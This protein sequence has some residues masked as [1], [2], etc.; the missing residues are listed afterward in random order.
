MSAADDIQEVDRLPGLPHPR[1][2][3]ALIGQSA[4][5][6]AFLD[7]YKSGRFPH[8]WILAGPE[9]VGKATFAYR[10]ARFVLSHPDFR[11]PQVQ[12]AR[13]LSVPADAPS[14]RRIVAQSH[15]SL[16]VLN[17]RW[18]PEKK[19]LPTEIPSDLVRK[20]VSFFGSTAGEGGWRVCIV[21]S[22]EDMNVTGMN[23]LLKVVEEPPDRSLFLIVSHLPGRL[24]PTIRSRCRIAPFRVL[25]PAEIAE[26][27]E[28][29]APGAFDPAT[30]RRAA[31]VADGS[32]RG[33]FK[34]LDEDTLAIVEHIRA[35]LERLPTLD[36]KDVHAI[37]EGLAG[38]ANEA[39]YDTAIE[40]VFA[41]LSER[42][43]A[44]AEEGPAR[45]AP[46]AEVWDKIARAVRETASYNLDR[47]ALVL[48]IFTDLADALRA[49]RAG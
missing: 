11:A 42:L 41:W 1:E 30:V 49:S 9:G 4:A 33:A 3:T 15:T 14:A 7:A 43:H 47:R 35:A 19:R 22:V 17:R 36:W 27:V 21:D 40:T 38:R 31:A 6:T 26:A 39:A 32:V 18:N 28:T 45:L 2:T 29:V 8:A 16:F 44:Q 37:A 23:S 20:A 46:L 13:D 5:E 48:T 34:L 10:A 24:L 12:A 25:T